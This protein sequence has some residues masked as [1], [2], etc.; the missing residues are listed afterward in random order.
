[1]N[2]LVWSWKRSLWCLIYLFWSV[3]GKDSNKI[4]EFRTEPMNSQKFEMHRACRMH[5]YSIETAI[6]QVW[7]SIQS[8]REEWYPSF[9]TITRSLRVVRTSTGTCSSFINS[10]RRIKFLRLCKFRLLFLHKLKNHKQS[11]F[12]GNG[13]MKHTSSQ[14]GA[15][16]RVLL[17]SNVPLLC[18]HIFLIGFRPFPTW[19]WSFPVFKMPEI[20]F[21]TGAHIKYTKYGAFF[22]GTQA[23]MLSKLIFFSK[24][25]SSNNSFLLFDSWVDESDKSEESKKSKGF[26]RLSFLYLFPLFN[27]E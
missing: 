5:C 9:L 26:L 25:K 2:F 8:T 6:R 7:L 14:F 16:A 12:E 19:V 22:G 18:C 13:P 3:L 10:P 15:P 24:I 21:G 17:L 20:G 11:F 1:L 23:T 4:R 27:V